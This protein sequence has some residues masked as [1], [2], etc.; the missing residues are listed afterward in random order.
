MIYNQCQNSAWNKQK[1]DA[2]RIMRLII[3]R[4]EF[5]IDQVDRAERRGQ[6]EYFHDCVVQRDEMS[7]QIQVTCGKDECEQDLTFAR[8]TCTK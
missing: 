5:E 1:L 3:C 4:F 2:K 7:E 8:N 6:V